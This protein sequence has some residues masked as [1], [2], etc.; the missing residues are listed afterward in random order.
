ME[1]FKWYRHVDTNEEREL[2]PIRGVTMPHSGP[3][4][5]VADHKH[6]HLMVDRNG[7]VYNADCF[8]P[9]EK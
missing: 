7:Q 2:K 3:S 6:Y 9:K 8:E 1:K 4:A 5:N